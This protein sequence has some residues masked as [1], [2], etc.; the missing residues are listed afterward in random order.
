MQ[1]NGFGT[2]SVKTCFGCTAGSTTELCVI[3]PLEHLMTQGMGQRGLCTLKFDGHLPTLMVIS[4][5][6]SSSPRV[7]SSR[8]KP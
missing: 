1:S 4:P 7:L 5:C 3:A 6:R 2:S 8:A